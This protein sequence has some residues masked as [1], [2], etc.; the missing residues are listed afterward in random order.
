[1]RRILLAVLLI[2]QLLPDA[3]SFAQEFSVVAGEWPPY[4]SSSM[5]NKGLAS[6]IVQQAMQHAGL[7]SRLTIL[8]WRRCEAETL[9]GI[10]FGTFPYYTNSER[11]KLFLYSDPLLITSV[12]FFYRRDRLPNFNY[13]SLSALKDLKVGGILG[14]YYIPDFEE[15]GIDAI[16]SGS[17]KQSFQQLDHGWIDVVAEGTI[18]GWET[19][20]ELFPNRYHEFAHAKNPIQVGKQV[21]MVS[22]KW[23]GGRKILGQFNKGLQAI[24]E[25]G[26]YEK[27][28][29]K[30]GALHLVYSKAPIVAE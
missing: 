27:I 14:Y 5:P 12:S 17:A 1:M 11:D 28:L 15:A 19:L 23:L 7:E 25:N 6:E 4:T 22:K 8:P 20:K 9:S 3:P 21:L 18:P 29:E 26:I 30:H 2:F 24:R 16:Y 10:H 13:T